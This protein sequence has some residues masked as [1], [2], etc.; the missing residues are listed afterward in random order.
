MKLVSATWYSAAYKSEYALTL[1]MHLPTSR[2]L[3]DLHA[4]SAPLRS[5]LII[6]MPS[7]MAR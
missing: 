7:S 3:L 2:D 5:D 1:P 6:V 4:W